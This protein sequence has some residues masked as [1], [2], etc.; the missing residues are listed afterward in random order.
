[1]RSAASSK[2][3]HNWAAGSVSIYLDHAASTPLDPDV[4]EAMLPFLRNDFGNP[5]SMHEVGRRARNAIDVARD[6]VAAS[7]GAQPREIV[8]TSGG[9]EADNLAI[10]GALDRQRQRGRHVVTTAIE[11][12]AV[13]ETLAEIAELDRADVTV[14]GCDGAGRVDAE[15][16]AAAVRDDTVLVSVML[17]NNEVGTIQEL[18]DVARLVKQ[19]NPQALVHSDAVQALGKLRVDVGE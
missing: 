1:M 15:E 10:R 6:Q 12:E 2:S 9:T 11:H 8:F 19:R 4:L 16:V 3:G 14:V 5:S 18:A 7:I 13:L 17:V